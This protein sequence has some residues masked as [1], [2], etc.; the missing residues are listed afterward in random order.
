MPISDA[1]KGITG[2]FMRPFEGPYFIS[3]EL[4]PAMFELEDNQGKPRGMFNKRDLKPF[5]MKT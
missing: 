5:R 1:D 4:S 2:K 3:K